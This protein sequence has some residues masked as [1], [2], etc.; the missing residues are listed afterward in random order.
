MTLYIQ[1]KTVFEVIY[2]DFMSKIMLLKDHTRQNSYL[3][4]TLIYQVIR[5]T[6]VPFLCLALFYQVILGTTKIPFHMSCFCLPG[7]LDTT[8]VPFQ[9]AISSLHKRIILYHLQLE[10]EVNIF[11]KRKYLHFIIVFILLVYV[12]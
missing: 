9:A 12:L 2:A 7:H 10:G 5:T 8:K 6:Q 3:Y 4:F 1:Y 11:F